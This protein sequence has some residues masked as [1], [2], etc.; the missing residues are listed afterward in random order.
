MVE[1][2]NTAH[3]IVEPLHEASVEG[4]PKL[5]QIHRSDRRKQVQAACKSA[6]R[7]LELETKER[8]RVQEMYDLQVQMG[9][10]GVVIGVDE[11]GRGAIAGPLYVGAVALPQG[12]KVWGINDSKQLSPQR[13]EELASQIADVATAIG[14]GIVSAE[15]IDELGMAKALRFAMAQAIKGC[16]IEPDCVLIDG[17]PAHVH[18]KEKCLVK[19]D[20][21]VA[22]IAAASIVAKVTRDHYMEQVSQ[23]YPAYGWDR[24]KGYGSADHIAAIKRYGL[25]PYHRATFCTHF[26]QGTQY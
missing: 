7:R 15:K 8:N 23:E 13:R 12:P 18:P 25:T 10:T 16:R 20:A 11:V 5:I 3:A 17:N 14:F 9:G 22:C 26:V 4:L 1:K 21:R 19:G 24:C 2:R 6:E